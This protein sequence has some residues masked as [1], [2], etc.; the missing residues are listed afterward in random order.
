MVSHRSLGIRTFNLFW[1]VLLVTA[2]FWLWLWIWASEIFRD[3]G[4]IQQYLVHSEFLVIGLLFGLGSKRE[5]RG[6]EKEW[7]QANRK[8]LRQAFLA[9]LATCVV[10]LAGRGTSSSGSF[11]LIL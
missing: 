7:V 1:Q 5:A 3:P 6:P 4:A 9:L 8:S 10:V 2:T 11:L